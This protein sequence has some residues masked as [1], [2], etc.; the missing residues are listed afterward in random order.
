MRIDRNE[1]RRIAE[2]ASLEFDPEHE[3]AMSEQMSRIL[4]Y[5][6]QLGEVDVAA[7]PDEA[8]TTPDPLRDDTRRESLPIDDVASN[9]PRF[10]H[11]FFVVPRIIGGD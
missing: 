11:G 10:V 7:I 4:D 9:A 3:A 5:I 6:D 1:V 8:V 2:L